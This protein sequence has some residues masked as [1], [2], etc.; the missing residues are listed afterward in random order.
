[1]KTKKS[2]VSMQ[3][4]V[5]ASVQAIARECGRYAGT[6]KNLLLPILAA[7]LAGCVNLHV[8]FPEA[9]DK[10]AA[11]EAPAQPADAGSGAAK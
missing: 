10:P 8:Y 5:Q 3:A 2:E 4:S 11:A 9:S 1:M 6:K 7:L